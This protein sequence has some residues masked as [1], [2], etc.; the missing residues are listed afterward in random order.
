MFSPDVCS[1]FDF[2]IRGQPLFFVV[3]GRDGCM[4]EL[5]LK[6]KKNSV[7]FRTCSINNGGMRWDLRA[8]PCV[9]VLECMLVFVRVGICICLGA[10]IGIF[11]LHLLLIGRC[12]PTLLLAPMI[13]CRWC[14]CWSWCWCWDSLLLFPP[15]KYCY[16][17]RIIVSTLFPFQQNLQ[18]KTRQS[19]GHRFEP[20]DFGLKLICWKTRLLSETGFNQGLR[21]N[22]MASGVV[23]DDV[24]SPLDISSFWEPFSRL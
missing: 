23:T 5:L 17:T 12:S 21:S 15:S 16:Y 14:W 3:P 8:E 2:L 19:C 18:T 9:F 4:Q 22:A 13:S 1:V 20:D 10:A 11:T 24:S 6:A 7:Q